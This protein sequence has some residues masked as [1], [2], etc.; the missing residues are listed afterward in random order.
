MQA[1]IELLIEKY[2]EVMCHMHVCAGVHLGV[3]IVHATFG[4][5]YECLVDE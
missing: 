2:P 4:A 5:V 3:W 1:T